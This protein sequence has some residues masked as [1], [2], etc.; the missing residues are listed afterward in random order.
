MAMKLKDIK[1]L[2]I[3]LV[4]L[5]FFSALAY[6]VSATEEYAEITGLDCDSCHIDPMGGGD[7]TSFGKGY[8][9]SIAPEAGAVGGERSTASRVIRLIFLYIHIVTGFMWFGTILYVHLVLKPAY[10][11]KGLPS[12]EVKVGLISIIVMAVTGSVLTWYKV[13]SLDQLLSSTFGILLLAKITIFSIMVISAL[14][15]VL[16]IGPK[17]KKK[18]ALPST[19]SENLNIEE[20]AGFDGLEGRPAY[21]AYK[22]KIYDVSKSKL[23]PNGSHIKRHQAG[24]DLTDVLAQ[25]PHGEEKIPA[26]PEVG[27]LV[28]SSATAKADLSQKVFYFMAYMNLSFVFVI[29]F[30]LALWRW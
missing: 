29:T 13:S 15:V 28:A 14:F 2:S 18:I 22:G 19:Q 24:F 12:G 25:A 20:L 16:V 27:L 8:L 1:S 23:W 5:L 3:I 9:A 26:M 21:F 11:S 17:L 30:I 7:L 10:A 4:S 6:P